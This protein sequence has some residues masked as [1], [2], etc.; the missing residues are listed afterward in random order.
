MKKIEFKNLKDYSDLPDL[1]KNLTTKKLK[2]KKEVLREFNTEKWG[3]IL[4]Y[5]KS[6]PN[7]KL[8]EVDMFMEDFNKTNAF[9]Y[10]NQF[11]LGSGKE[12]F[13]MHIGLYAKVM[14]D[15]IKDSSCLVEL[16]AG[17][18][19]KILNI[20]QRKEFSHLPLYA[21]EY[22]SNGCESMKILAKRMNRN[23]EVGKCDFKELTIDNIMIPEGG[24]IFTSYAVHYAQKLS[25]KFIDYIKALKPRVVIHFEPIYEYHNNDKFGQMCK[26]YIEIN[27]YNLNMGT[28]FNKKMQSKEINLKEKK[29]VLGGNPF[30]PLSVAKWSL[31]DNSLNKIII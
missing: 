1:I 27:D 2:T 23:I 18:G 4:D 17:Y 19:S 7:K 15:Y 28:I 5:L 16:G 14:K 12:I 20:S 25:S 9:F 6:D 13:D 31:A 11:L 29:N 30:L 22:T 8:Y 26:K 24:I 21:A 10:N 3:S